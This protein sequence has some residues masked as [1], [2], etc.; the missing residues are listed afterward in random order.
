MVNSNQDPL[1]MSTPSAKR[2][3]LC[4]AGQEKVGKTT[5][6]SGLAASHPLFVFNADNRT[7]ALT[8]DKDVAGNIISIPMGDRPA[9]FLNSM[10]SA[11]RT[12]PFA[13]SL[14]TGEESRSSL[15]PANTGSYIRFNFPAFPNGGIIALDSWTAIVQ[16]IQASFVDAHHVGV[17]DGDSLGKLTKDEKRDGIAYYAHASLAQAL[18]VSGFFALPYHRVIVA[19]ITEYEET[20]TSGVVAK[21]VWVKALLTV[22]SKQ[23]TSLA[24]TV[25]DILRIEEHPKDPKA[26]V[27]C[28]NKGSTTVGG[29]ESLPPFMKA[30][31]SYPASRYLEEVGISPSPISL[32]E[33]QNFVSLVDTT[34]G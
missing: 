22:S 18:L 4:L 34:K 26:M 14:L 19:H 30:L 21:K 17:F 1:S 9:K 23:A 15:P 20:R 31:E 3:S 2:I 29:C 12:K 7:G 28:T 6:L 5:W 32:T 13:I 11:D 25:G 24:S 10:L 8:R 27:I 16:G 33:G